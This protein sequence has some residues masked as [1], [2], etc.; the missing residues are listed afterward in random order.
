ML[1]R[2]ELIR[3][4]DYNPV[5]GHFTTKKFS[6]YCNKDYGERAGCIHKTKGYRYIC[7]AGKTYREQRL[8]FLF[9]TGSWPE[10]QVD[11]VNRIK[12]DNRWCNL[13]D[14][15]PSVNCQNRG[16]FANNTSGYRGVTWNKLCSKWQVLCRKEN[17]PY[18]LGLFDKLEEAAAI[19]E[20]FY[21]TS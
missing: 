5:T 11:H 19:S 8:A 21:H 15:S 13:R 3:R 4:I 6:K 2:E 16:K 20:N 17:K 10:G 14:V 1:T 9:M 7:I 18:Y 12:D